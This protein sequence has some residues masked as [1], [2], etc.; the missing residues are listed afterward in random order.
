MHLKLDSHPPVI[1]RPRLVRGQ[2]TGGLQAS[3][4]VWKGRKSVNVKVSR[5]FEIKW[6][7]NKLIVAFNM[8]NWVVPSSL[9]FDKHNFNKQTN[10]THH[11]ERAV[12]RW[13]CVAFESP[14]EEDFQRSS[15]A[16]Q[17]CFLKRMSNVYNLHPVFLKHTG[18]RRVIMGVYCIVQPRLV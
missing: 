2:R 9:I 3:F 17:L 4:S 8:R 13:Q 14:N 11:D 5:T 16:H 7:L 1:K 6:V 12:L 10:T 18:D 15:L